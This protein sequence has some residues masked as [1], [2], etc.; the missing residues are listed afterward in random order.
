VHSLFVVELK[1]QFTMLGVYDEKG[2]QH[3]TSVWYERELQYMI[4]RII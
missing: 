3:V 2:K 1:E 4:W